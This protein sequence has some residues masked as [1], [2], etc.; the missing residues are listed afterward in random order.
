MRNNDRYLNKSTFVNKKGHPVMNEYLD[1]VNP[2]VLFAFERNTRPK[3]RVVT[4]MRS[5]SVCIPP[6]SSDGLTAR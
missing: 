1:Y 5:R 4:S 2:D 6:P 3:T